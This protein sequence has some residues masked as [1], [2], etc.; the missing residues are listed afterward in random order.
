MYVYIHL[1]IDQSSM[2]LKLYHMILSVS[3][4]F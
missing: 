3:I 2:V 1:Y 4:P